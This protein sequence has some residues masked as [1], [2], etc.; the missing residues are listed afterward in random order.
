[1]TPS[2]NF[3]AG[4]VKSTIFV[5]LSCVTMCAPCT[6]TSR[7]FQSPGFSTCSPSAVGIAT[8]PRPPLSYRPPGVLAYIRVDLHLHPFKVWA[9]L[10]VDSQDS[11]VEK[12]AAV[13][14]SL[15]LELK[16]QREIPIRLFCG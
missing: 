13:A 1:M 6:E 4:S 3:G 14:G 9:M 10:G 16:A 11:R 7:S 2:V 12:Y 5:P 15:A 8:Q